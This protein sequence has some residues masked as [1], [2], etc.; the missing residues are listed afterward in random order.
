M[1]GSQKQIEWAT[2]IIKNANKAWDDLKDEVKP[3]AK[4]K[5]DEMKSSFFERMQSDQA[6]A[7]ISNRMSF[8]ENS[9][10]LKANM[11]FFAKVNL[12]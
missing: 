2:E 12:V 4:I 6:G 1:K 7:I 10:Q 9:G 11:G 3:E 8:P 5:F